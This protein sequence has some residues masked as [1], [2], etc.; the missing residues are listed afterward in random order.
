MCNMFVNSFYIL[1]KNGVAN[2]FSV[3]F[4]SRTK[5]GRGVSG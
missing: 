5:T 2:L 3:T 1:L 4:D